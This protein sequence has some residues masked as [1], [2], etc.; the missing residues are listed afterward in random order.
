MILTMH[1]YYIPVGLCIERVAMALPRSRSM[2]QVLV[3]YNFKNLVAMDP[4]HSLRVKLNYVLLTHFSLVLNWSIKSIDL[5]SLVIRF[6]HFFGAISVSTGL[7]KANRLYLETK[8]P[9]WKYDVTWCPTSAGVRED[10]TGGRHGCPV[11]GWQEQGRWHLVP[12]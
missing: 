6:Q 8:W 9:G 10:D 5:R 3:F 4:Q 2:N 7:I 11:W 12:L 1:R